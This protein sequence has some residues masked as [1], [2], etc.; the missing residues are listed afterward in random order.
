MDAERSEV[1]NA[2]KTTSLYIFPWT[3]WAKKEKNIEKCHL[4]TIMSADG[5]IRME[6]VKPM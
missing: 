1:Q 6:V 5:S 2:V 3:E 4:Q